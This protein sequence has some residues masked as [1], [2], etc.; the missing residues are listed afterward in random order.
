MTMQTA[1]MPSASNR[2]TRRAPS[3]T[4]RVHSPTSASGR[5]SGCNPGGGP[6]VEMHPVLRRLRRG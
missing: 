4:K 3:A 1:V 5:P 6:Q 2:R